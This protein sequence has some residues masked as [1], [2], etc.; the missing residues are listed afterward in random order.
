MRRYVYISGGVL[1][2]CLIF[3]PSMLSSGY[4]YLLSFCLAF[5]SAAADATSNGTDNPIVNTQNGSYIGIHDDVFNQDFFLKIPYAQVRQ[6]LPRI[7]ST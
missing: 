7:F 3:N 5:T 1:F 4:G 6:M 2:L